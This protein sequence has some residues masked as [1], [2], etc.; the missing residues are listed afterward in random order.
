MKALASGKLWPSSKN[1]FERAQSEM[2]TIATICARGGS[3]GLPRKNVLPLAGRPLIVHSIHQALAHPAIDLVF[4][5][6]DDIEI[7]R[8][9]EEAGAGVP[10]LRP[11]HLATDSAAKAPV[12]E[13][14]VRRLEQDGQS[15]DRIVDLQPTSP[16]RMSEDITACLALLDHDSDCVI[17]VCAAAENPYFNLVELDCDGYAQISK[18][19]AGA[20]VARQQSPAVF[21][22]NG[23]AYCWHR[24]TLDKG[25]L[26][27]RTKVHVMPRERSIDIDSELDFRIVELLIAERHNFS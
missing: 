8:I 10:Y 23:S 15:I 19:L 26:G 9:A 1:G 21:A 4:V 11:S 27:G 5:S 13:H 2:T 18:G 3:Q 12:I 22:V 25:V 24:D 20:V 7:A 17:A 6:T 16:L 14:L